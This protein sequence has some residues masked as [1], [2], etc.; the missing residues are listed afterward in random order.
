MAAGAKLPEA[1]QKLQ[2]NWSVNCA[3]TEFSANIA[4][5]GD[6]LGLSSENKHLLT[7]KNGTRRRININ[8]ND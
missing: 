5:V 4:T 6:S 3:G 1:L 7:G 8:L 2:S